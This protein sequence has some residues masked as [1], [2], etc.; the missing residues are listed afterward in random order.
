MN[1]VLNTDELKKITG[2]KQS[3]AIEKCLRD[4]G[5]RYF[6]GKNGPWTTLDLINAAKG[7]T[8]LVQT[9]NKEIL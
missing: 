3:G 1:D 2:F 5:V 4:Q 6:H 8:T 7:L 9:T